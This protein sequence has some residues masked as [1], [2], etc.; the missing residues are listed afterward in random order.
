MAAPEWAWGPVLAPAETGGQ[1]DITLL[2]SGPPHHQHHAQVDTK[3]SSHVPGPILSFK[4]ISQSVSRL[5]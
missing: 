3:Y 5:A 1:V 2:H 4:D